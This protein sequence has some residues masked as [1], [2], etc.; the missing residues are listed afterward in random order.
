MKGAIAR[1]TNS[2][3]HSG[4]DHSAAIR[5]P[6]QPRDSPQDH[7]R[8]NLERHRGHVD[9]LISGI[10]TGG[11]ITGVGQVIKKREPSFYVVAVEPEE[12]PPV[13]SG[14]QPGPHKVQGIGAG[15]SRPRSSTPLFM[16]RS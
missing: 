10:G 15:F 14:G 3:H 13:L 2:P 7:R 8:G 9:I 4:R 6:G 12:P 11:T 5:K 16:T 1:P